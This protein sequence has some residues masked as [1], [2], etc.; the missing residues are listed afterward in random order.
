M[1]IRNLIAS[2]FVTLGA[3]A[4]APADA[5]EG[6]ALLLEGVRTASI[7]I[8][9]PS[10]TTFDIERLTVTGNG[11]FVGFYAESLDVPLA[12][13]SDP[14]R[15][16]GV[17]QIRDWHAP[18]GPA[19]RLDFAPESGNT[20][21]AG[22]YRLYL[23]ADGR[24]SVRLPTAG[25]VVRRLNP[26]VTATATVAASTDVLTSPFEAS[27]VQRLDL[28]GKRSVS[29]S[30]ILIGKSRAY[31]GTIG[32][33]LRAPGA[34]CGEQGID[35][36]FA[37]FTVSPLNEVDFAFVVGYQPGVLAPG[38]YEADQ[39]AINATTL[40]YASAAAFSLDLT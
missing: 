9:L 22:R 20:L 21:R 3:V 14:R 37:G 34:E 18:G 10:D 40:Q 25:S 28:S 24:A 17:V 19:M 23:L 11:R 36:G 8:T 29:F 33:C 7:D 15:H 27:N 26:K 16:L 31:A 35:G 1:R 32:A 2:L 6:G 4:A 30:G 5:V 39:G 13:R 12:N 38:A